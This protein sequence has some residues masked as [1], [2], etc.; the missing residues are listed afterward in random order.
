[1]PSSASL[2][3]FAFLRRTET[4]TSINTAELDIPLSTMRII[5]RAGLSDPAV[6]P[7]IA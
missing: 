7:A 3:W 2:P 5:V 6:A 1:M 4:T